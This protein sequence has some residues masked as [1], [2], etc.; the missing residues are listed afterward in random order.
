MNASSKKRVSP[1]R[2][3]LIDGNAIIHRA[4]H[5]LPKTLTTKK[6]ELTN[7]VYGF[8]NMLLRII[9]DLEPS[10]IAVCFDRKEPTFRHKE[11]E[12]YQAHRPEMDE[13]LS[14]Q[15]GKTKDVV[16]TFKIPIYEKAGYEADDVIG[17]LAKKGKREFEEIDIVTG[18]RDILQLVDEKIKV[19][20]PQ[21]GLSNA[22]LYG[23]RSVQEK[24]GVTP[25]QIVDYKGLVGDP[26]DNYKGVP[27]IGPKTAEKLLK[28]YKSFPNIYK[29]LSK[30]D[31]R[32]REKLTKYQKDAE[33]SYKLAK[34]IT[35]IKDIDIDSQ[36]MAK[37]HIGNAETVALFEKYG[38][39]TLTKRIREFASD[40][41]NQTVKK[42]LTRADVEKTAK[43]L[44]KLC[45]NKQYAIRG[46]AS[47][48]LQDIKM[49]VDD[50]DI[51]CDKKTALFFNKKLKNEMVE[52][53]EFG[54]SQNFKS[55]FGRFVMDKISVEVMGE[56]QI[57]NKKKK[58]SKKFD[59]SRDQ[60]NSIEIG[61]QKIKVTK[62]E[63][64][65][66]MFAAM[67]R[68]N[69]FHKIKKQLNSKRQSSLF[70]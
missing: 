68:W 23:K 32:I 27:G 33:L 44:A 55:Y 57:K 22:K 60:I 52:K 47:L 11:F 48:L 43:K 17:T 69:A 58:W 18:D 5:A 35:D 59:A 39:K 61:G 13:G 51:I 53:V 21:R 16:K 24:L 31:K 41:S 30:I 12:D 10:H 67:G 6:G 2:L 63:T 26:S 1:K 65:L 20:L 7:A 64:E 9:K 56:W 25:K 45:R 29:N 46:T 14:E 28:E 37:W 8:T 15:F 49:G 62:V 54:E 70:D 3:V 40:N 34:I 42:K 19:Y 50:I 36:E 4:Y 66:E 38:F